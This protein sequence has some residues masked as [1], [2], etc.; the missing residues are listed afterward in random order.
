MVIVSASRV[1][2]I[3]LLS[4]FTTVVAINAEEM[5]IMPL[6]DSITYGDSFADSENPRPTGARAAYRSHLYY[7]LQDIGYDADFVGSVTA[8]ENV[9]PPFDPNNEGHPGWSSYRVADH[10]DEFLDQNHADIVLL[11][12]GTNDHSDNVHGMENILGW[13]ES[14]TGHYRQ[15]D[16]R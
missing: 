15:T 11:H 2:K 5:K 1:C 16:L 7:R 9:S 13:I 6:G 10:V 8:G 4:L 12:A 14:E 3:M